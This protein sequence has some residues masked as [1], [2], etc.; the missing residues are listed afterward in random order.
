MHHRMCGKGLQPCPLLQ[1]TLGNNWIESSAGACTCMFRAPETVFTAR[2]WQR[3]KYRQQEC[4]AVCNG[5]RHS[6]RAQAR[7]RL[8]A[9]RGSRLLVGEQVAPGEG[10]RGVGGADA[11]R[12]DGLRAATHGNGEACGGCTAVRGSMRRTQPTTGPHA[13]FVMEY[14]VRYGLGGGVVCGAFGVG[15]RAQAQ[16]DTHVGT[17][18]SCADLCKTGV[19][20]GLRPWV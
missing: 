14:D 13:A 18:V 8:H 5:A 20:R 19:N 11:V 4:K 15:E 10:P 1:H 7:A 3:L 9:G 12:L 6:Q 17:Y 2:P 16:Q